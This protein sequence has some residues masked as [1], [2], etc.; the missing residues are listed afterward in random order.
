MKAEFAFWL[1]KISIYMSI[2]ERLDYTDKQ[3]AESKNMRRGFLE[4]LTG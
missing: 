4:I 2:L 3:K 1:F